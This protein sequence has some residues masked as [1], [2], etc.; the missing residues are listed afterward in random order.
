MNK[1][2]VPFDPDFDRPTDNETIVLKIDRQAIFDALT[3]ISLLVTF[4]F[5][6]KT[7]GIL[8]IWQ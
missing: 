6:W 3:V 1:V 7:Y 8:T 4:Y 2:N 5:I